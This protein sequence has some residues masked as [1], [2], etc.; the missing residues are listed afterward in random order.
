MKRA[1][2]F[3]VIYALI[4]GAFAITALEWGAGRVLANRDQGA[5]AH[6]G[7]RHLFHPFR[8][9]Q[10]NPDYRRTFDT[11]G[12]KIHSPDG[13]RSDV[14]IKKNKPAGVYRII[15]LGGSTL[16][17]IGAVEPYPVTPS[18][19]NSELVSGLLEKELNAH[20]ASQGRAQK[21]EII[22]AGVTG[23][24]TLQHLVYFNEV[25]Y[26]Y[27]PD[28]LVFLDGHN[29]FYH[30]TVYNNW[31]AARGGAA[32][33][34]PHFNERT[35]WF[36]RLAIV[37]YLA[38]SSN[39]FAV[40]ERYMQRSWPE[41]PSERYPQADRPQVEPDV[42]SK[43]VETVLKESI[44]KSYIQFQ[45]LSKHFGFDM[46]VFLQPQVA[47]ESTNLLSAADQKIQAITAQHE[48]NRRRS[49]IRPFFA[50]EFARYGLPFE[51]VAQIAQGQTRE[52]Q[53][54]LDYCHLTPAGSQA[55]AA[56][57]YPAVKARLD[58]WLS[59]TGDAGRGSKPAASSNHFGVRASLNWAPK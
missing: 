19:K 22:N 11:R 29:D 54:Y 32:D 14:P 48:N 31:Q 51:D 38:S 39:V 42:L 37:R 44:F 40:I 7:S 43:H 47:L 26:E 24:T 57:M 15:M 13:F 49:E 4:V 27:K 56:R 28:L 33:L 53:L 23:Y 9:Y 36:T 8:L 21:V 41:P 58:D 18:L 55:V 2:V 12:E 5:D 10:L 3:Y 46:M 52:T 59:R 1:T 6:S 30:Y 17:G 25:L 16:Y 20:L 34:I 35:G 45:A 50:R